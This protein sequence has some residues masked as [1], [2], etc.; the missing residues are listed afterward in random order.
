MELYELYELIGLQ[1]EII[2]KL[3]A[4]GEQMDFTQ[5]DFHLEQLMNMKTA[6][7]SYKYL[8]SIW[9]ED[10]DQIKMLY[11]QLEC[12]RRVYA[13]YLSQ[14][15]PK[16]IYIDT[17]K[18]FVRFIE[19]CGKKNGRMFFDRGWW[20]YRQ[21]SMNIFRIGELEYQFDTY[22]DENVIGLHIPSDA[23]LSEK[24]VNQSLQQAK[25]FFQTYYSDYEY[26]HYTCNSWLLSP[27]LTPLLS[28][29]SHIL[30]FQRRFDILQEN[31]ADQEYIEWL[32]QVPVDTD[33]H[34]LPA[35]TNLQKKVKELL[36]NGKTVGCAFGIIKAS[37]V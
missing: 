4:A 25:L 19:E 31:R 29:T 16:T 7:S 18:C 32:F 8:N 35:E 37:V 10:T 12:A 6:A 30:S 28:E 20:T 14:H 11:C 3:N 17:M 13:R 24:A 23:D 36:L 22:E 2:Q 1:P 5:L 15:I 27:V 26:R 21:L 33:C 9:K 34:S